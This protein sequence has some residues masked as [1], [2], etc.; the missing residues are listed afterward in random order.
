MT[1]EVVVRRPSPTLKRITR[2]L[3]GHHSFF[4][5]EYLYQEALF[6]LWDGYSRRAIDDR[7][8]S[9][10]LQGCYYHLKNYLRTVHEKALCTSLN[11]PI[12]KDG[13]HLE[14][15]MLSFDTMTPFDYLE[16]KL[17]A[18]GIMN[19]SHFTGKEQKVLLLLMDGMTVR[20]IGSRLGVS[21]V[22]VVKIK[23]KICKK[24]MQF[25]ASMSN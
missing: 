13:A 19:K 2:R 1:L 10:I 18:E 8:D 14:E 22:M 20:E 17:E 15:E 21:H 24:Y 23:S 25:R 16:G 7:A 11:D 4:D 3:N 9:Y 6:H 5:D 12:G